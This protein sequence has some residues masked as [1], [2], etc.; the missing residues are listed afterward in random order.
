MEWDGKGKEKDVKNNK[1]GIRKKGNKGKGK[2][3]NLRNKGDKGKRRKRQSRRER[4]IFRC[5]G[6]CQACALLGSSV[7]IC[8]C[9]MRRCQIHNV[10]EKICAR[11]RGATKERRK[12]ERKESATNLPTGSFAASF[13]AK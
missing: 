11:G 6:S 9:K 2:K 10:P 12:M 1:K 4:Y 3:G 7:Q 8:D 5:R 13:M